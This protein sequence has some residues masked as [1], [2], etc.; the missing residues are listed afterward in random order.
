MAVSLE[1]N[2]EQRDVLAEVLGR[3]LGD[4]SHEIADTDLS[5]FKEQLK[6]RR[7]ALKAIADQL[8]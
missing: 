6:A 3:V 5:S 1:L 7:D 2:D 4:M 8:S